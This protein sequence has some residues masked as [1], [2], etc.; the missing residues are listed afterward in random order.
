MAKS[1]HDISFLIKEGSITVDSGVFLFEYYMIRE[2]SK[3]LSSFFS[4]KDHFLSL[5]LDLLIFLSRQLGYKANQDKKEY[6][7][8]QYLQHFQSANLITLNERHSW[9]IMYQGFLTYINEKQ[10]LNPTDLVL[11]AV[12]GGVDSM[13]MST[14]FTQTNYSFGVAHVNYQ[15]RGVDSDDDARL[16]ERWCHDRGVPFHKRMV[17]SEVY[18][19]SESIQMVARKE[20]YA[21]FNELMQE[22]GYT[23]VATAHN[24]NDALETV[25][26]N[27]TKGTG[28]KGLTGIAPVKEGRIRPLLFATKAEVYDYARSQG[29]SWREDRSNKKND[30]Q[31][32]LIRNE[33]VPL[34]YKINPNLEHTFLDTLQRL[35]GSEEIV[36]EKVAS[37]KAF[38]EEGFEKLDLNWFQN[39]NKDLVLLS[40][41]LRAYGFSFVEIKSL[42]RAID[43][44][45]SG[46]L[47][48]SPSHQV[49]LDRNALWIKKTTDSDDSATFCE[50]KHEGQKRFAKKVFNLER[51]SGEAF[52]GKNPE[53]VAYL[54]RERIVFPLL[55]RRWREGDAFYPLG[56]R[57]KK[58]V[59]DFMIDSKIPVTLKQE[60]LILESEG[61]IVW[62]VGYRLD[63]RFKVTPRTVQ[64]LKIEVTDHV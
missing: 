13:V 54:D 10:L 38:T 27:L 43:N 17:N 5:I 49:N 24:A 34:L 1:F 32:N 62:V 42:A 2:S 55:V 3:V 40:E 61:K 4:F 7:I 56:M 52:P 31:R 36:S 30:Y 37:I 9:E 18:D 15:L 45:H 21:F 47:F 59:S 44:G 48:H 60:V 64:L 19:S 16:V 25:L 39:T 41:A 50:I 29:I 14:L 23:K 22:F 28:I 57:G 26:L 11:L 35:Q 51:L 20:R 33:V 58:K 6:I 12:S 63:D 8:L 53:N 46:K